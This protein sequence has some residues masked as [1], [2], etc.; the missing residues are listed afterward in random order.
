MR[1]PP[2][3]G[4]RARVCDRAARS[5]SAGPEGSLTW[6]HGLFVNHSGPISFHRQSLCAKP[7]CCLLVGSTRPV[8]N[9]QVLYLR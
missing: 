3:M 9:G 2:G 5:E 1:R 7:G 4:G 8:S 6:T